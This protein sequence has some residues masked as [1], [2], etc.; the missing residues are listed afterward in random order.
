MQNQCWFYRPVT[1]RAHPGEMHTD[2]L[3]HSNPRTH[4]HGSCVAKPVSIGI[5][6]CYG[7]DTRS[8]MLFPVY[9]N[10]AA[11]PELFTFKSKSKTPSIFLC[12][13]SRYQYTTNKQL[14]KVIASFQARHNY[15]VSSLGSKTCCLSLYK[16]KYSSKYLLYFNKTK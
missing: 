9:L 15:L 13:I 8:V 14:S 1:F 3:P 6:I 16:Q 2:F 7:D 10:L 4:T 11:T 5:L 12:C